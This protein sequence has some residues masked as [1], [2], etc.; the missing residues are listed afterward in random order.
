MH[1]SYLLFIGLSHMAACS[2]KTEPSDV[3]SPCGAEL[4]DCAG[5]LHCVPLSTDCTDFRECHGTCEDLHSSPQPIYTICGGWDF[6]DDCDER[7]EYCTPDPRTNEHCGASC[8]AMAICAI[9]DEYC[10]GPDDRE[11]PLGKTCFDFGHD[12]SG[13]LWGNCFPLRF[14]SDTYEK[15]SEWEVIR[16]DQDGDQREDEE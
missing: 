3:G 6:I 15:S 13:T 8:D 7:V 12:D 14:G 16:Y 2:P 11:C 9:L 10:G 5:T 4:G 1:I